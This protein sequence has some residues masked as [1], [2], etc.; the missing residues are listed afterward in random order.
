MAEVNGP[1]PNYRLPK[2]LMEEKTTS[3]KMT[4]SREAHLA[5]SQGRGTQ[6][7]KAGTTGQLLSRA[8]CNDSQMLCFLSECGL[9]DNI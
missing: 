3:N 2:S 1:L 6:A 8:C 4:A 5:S 9:N 7:D